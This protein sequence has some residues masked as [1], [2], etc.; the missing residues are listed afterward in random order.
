MTPH[1][2]SPPARPAWKSDPLPQTKPPATP[3]YPSISRIKT[4]SKLA[5]IRIHPRAPLRQIKRAL[6]SLESIPLSPFAN[7]TW[8]RELPNQPLNLTGAVPS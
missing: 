8:A 6:C 1:V 2:V 3:P 4:S 5:S 7:D